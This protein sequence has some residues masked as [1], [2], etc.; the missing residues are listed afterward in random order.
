[1]IYFKLK[2]QIKVYYY[3]FI[4]HCIHLYTIKMLEGYI[5]YSPG[6]IFI[7]MH[8]KNSWIL[9]SSLCPSEFSNVVFKYKNYIKKI[10][11]FKSGVS[12]F[13]PSF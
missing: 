7:T 1:M 13:I 4:K 6:C 2:K 5:K 11:Y 8:W 9:F 10:V 12:P 3:D